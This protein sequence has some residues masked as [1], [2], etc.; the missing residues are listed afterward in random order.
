M[1]DLFALIQTLDSQR[2][3]MYGMHLRTHTRALTE[4]RKLTFSE[5]EFL[6]DLEVNIQKLTRQLDV[7]KKELHRLTKPSLIN[8][9]FWR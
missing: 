2:E 7:A 9:H 1:D 3:E 6:K 5:L 4:N 8:R